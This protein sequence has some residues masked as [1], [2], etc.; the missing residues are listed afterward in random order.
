M[1]IVL[2]YPDI[3][4]PSLLLGN[5]TNSNNSNHQS[6]YPSSLLSPTAYS[7][8]LNSAIFPT[9]LID[10]GSLPVAQQVFTPIKLGN[11]NKSD[12][13]MNMNSNSSTLHQRMKTPKSRN[14][15]SNNDNN[16]SEN[17][18]TLSPVKTSEWSDSPTI[19]A[20]LSPRTSN[21]NQSDNNHSTNSKYLRNLHQHQLRVDVQSLVSNN[22]NYN[23]PSGSINTPNRTQRS[24][25]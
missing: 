5:R 22:N 2:H 7:V 8:Q 13:N 17:D 15:N 24:T 18:H 23:S 12:S 3:L 25:R 11:N 19:E 14:D 4:P 20:F 1:Y 21:S 6:R 16:S 10:P 9:T